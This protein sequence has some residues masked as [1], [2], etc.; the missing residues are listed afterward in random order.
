MKPDTKSV[1]VCLVVRVMS[2]GSAEYA[3]SVLSIRRIRSD[4]A[5]RHD[6]PIRRAPLVSRLNYVEL[7]AGGRRAEQNS[8]IH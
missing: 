1:T 2:G 6:R 7:D 8:P 5:H 4:E 3:E